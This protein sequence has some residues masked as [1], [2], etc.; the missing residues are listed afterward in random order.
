VP[1]LPSVFSPAAV[2][3]VA[4][5]NAIANGLIVVTGGLVRLT[6]SGLGCPTWPRCT[7]DSFVAT[8][9]L[10]GHGAIEF[11]NRLLTFVLTAAA[12]ATVVVVWRSARRD[13]RPLA[14]VSFLGIPAQAL[15]GGVTVLTGLN[16]WTVAAHFLVSMLLVAVATTLWLRSR[17]PGVGQPLLRR[18]LEL[19]VLGIAAVTAAILV[20]GTVVTGAGPHSGDKNAS[21]RMD[22]DPETV[23]QLH[24]DLVFLLVGL[25]VALL[26]ALYAVNAPDRLRLAARDLLIVQLAQGLVGFVQYFT[27]LPIALVLVHMLGAVLIAAFTARLVWAVRGPASELPLGSMSSSV[28]LLSP[29][30]P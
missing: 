28:D 18:P 14:V 20:L 29:Q 24:A 17:E 15:L 19:L 13:L 27:D 9:E 4:L 25:T 6:G 12:I 1:V 2:S 22:F 26:V 5:I 10:A 3:R 7:D 23:S 21:D 11:G 16:P 8:P 30:R